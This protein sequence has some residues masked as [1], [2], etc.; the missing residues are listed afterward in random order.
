MV[1]SKNKMGAR[2]AINENLM[3]QAMRDCRAQHVSSDETVNHA[4]YSAFCAQCTRS[5]PCFFSSFFFT[6]AVLYS[7][8]SL[9]PYEY[10]G[11]NDM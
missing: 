3:S 7:L 2:L 9:F 6:A 10:V 11:L 5:V 4:S 8:V 1:T